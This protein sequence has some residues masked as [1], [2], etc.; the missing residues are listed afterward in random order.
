MCQARPT[1]NVERSR[2]FR[3][4]RR[5]RPCRSAAGRRGRTDRRGRDAPSL[6]GRGV[7]R[8]ACAS[9]PSAP[10][11][12]VDR[13]AMGMV[14]VP[15][16]V[17]N[18]EAGRHHPGST[19]TTMDASRLKVPAAKRTGHGASVRNLMAL[20]VT[21][22]NARPGAVQPDTIPA[23]RAQSVMAALGKPPVEKR[24]NVL[25]S[26]ASSHRLQPGPSSQ[27]RSASA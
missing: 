4:L 5:H 10:A 25:I 21:L 20:F 12:A 9:E 3:H 15:G 27:K 2:A 13:P 8:R 18:H 11:T 22:P 16:L 23:D 14:A 24:V 1:G 17:R 7:L 26:T 19:A 6:A